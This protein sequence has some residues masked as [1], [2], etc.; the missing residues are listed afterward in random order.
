M[1]LSLIQDCNLL[2]GN[3]FWKFVTWS[4]HSFK[5]TLVFGLQKED[6]LFLFF[7][8]EGIGLSL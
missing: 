8:K 6:E 5:P 2:V 4:S 7:A 1:F 3:M